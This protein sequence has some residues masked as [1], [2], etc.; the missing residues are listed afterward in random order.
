M[1]VRMCVFDREELQ[2]EKK[3]SFMCMCVCV[4]S[5]LCKSKECVCPMCAFGVS[6]SIITDVVVDKYTSAEHACF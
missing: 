2:R 4:P 3:S 5:Y 6:P 1:C